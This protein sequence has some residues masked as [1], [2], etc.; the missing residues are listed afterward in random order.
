[1]EAPAFMRGKE[2]FS[3]PG[4]S[5]DSIMRFSAGNARACAV[6]ALQVAEHSLCYQGTTLV[7]PSGSTKIWAVRSPSQRTFRPFSRVAVA[8]SFPSSR[9]VGWLKWMTESPL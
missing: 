4:N 6:P 9:H 7:G 1:V 2:R 5:L 3:A 8:G